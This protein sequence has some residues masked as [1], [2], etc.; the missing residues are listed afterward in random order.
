M[1][2]SISVHGRPRGGSRYRFG[3]A[4]LEVRV[5]AFDAP[6]RD[7]IADGVIG[8]AGSVL[9]FLPQIAFLFLFIGVLED[10]G[11]MARAAFMTDRLMAR[12]GLHGKSFIPLL[13]SFACAIPGILA[14]RT[15][16]SR[17]DRLVSQ[18]IG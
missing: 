18:S 1:W 5:A 9:Q 10:S 17:K 2:R 14:T 12:V 3:G 11:Y 6:G 16:E 13:S 7:L 8:G 4:V 15:I